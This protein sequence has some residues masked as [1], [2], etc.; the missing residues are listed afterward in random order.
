L[1]RNLLSK[2]KKKNE[3]DLPADSFA[4]KTCYRFDS[5]LRLYKMSFAD[6]PSISF[7]A[8][9]NEGLYSTVVQLSLIVVVYP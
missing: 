1:I 4:L 5:G 8:S 7:I 9:N 2:E 6:M 3:P